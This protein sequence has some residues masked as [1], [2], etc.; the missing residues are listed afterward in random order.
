MWHAVSGERPWQAIITSPLRRCS[1]FATLLSHELEIGVELDERLKEVGF[2]E[3]EGKTGDQLRQ[4]D[5]S[6][7]S[8]FY[9]DPI[10]NRPQGAENLDSFNQRVLAAY[11]DVCRRFQGQHL[12]LVTHAGVIRSIIS[13]TLQAPQSSMYRLSIATATLSRIQI[14]HERPPTL[15]HV[16]R[17][18]L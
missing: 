4:L 14:G 9:H 1:E 2:G 8:R 15:I 10:Q 3:W 18:R 6:V 11:K 7:L 13:H 12:L 5:P 17:T 16:A